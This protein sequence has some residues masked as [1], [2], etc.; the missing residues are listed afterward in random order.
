MRTSVLPV[1]RSTT[2]ASHASVYSVRGQVLNQ[3][4]GS[5]RVRKH[6]LYGFRVAVLVLITIDLGGFEHGV[7]PEALRV[8]NE[9]ATIGTHTFSSAKPRYSF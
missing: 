5:Q 4:G 2:Q 6:S 3:F 8:T 9:I 1:G 7:N